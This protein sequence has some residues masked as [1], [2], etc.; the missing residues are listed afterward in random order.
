MDLRADDAAHKFA[1]YHRYRSSA[2]A[3]RA[4]AGFPDILVVM[5]SPGAESRLARA[6]REASVGQPAV[7]RILLTTT[8][9]M[10]AQPE[11]L[12]GAIWR[13]PASTART[14]WPLS[15]SHLDARSQPSAPLTGMEA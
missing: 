12:L 13:D 7:L 3:A 1:A 10:Q 6:A 9:W 15:L 14:R 2:H 8:G 4:H 11:G 5:T